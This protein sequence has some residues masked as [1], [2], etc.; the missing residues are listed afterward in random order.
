MISKTDDLVEIS[1]AERRPPTTLAALCERDFKAS[2]FQHLHGGDA[3][4]RFV[5]TD[6]GVVPQNH[7]TAKSVLRT[8][9]ARKP[10]VK[11]LLRVMRQGPSRRDA[12]ESRRDKTRERRIQK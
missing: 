11:S 7:A 9:V 6:E 3:D 10:F 1:L 12:H 2:S 5:I 4:V 8:G